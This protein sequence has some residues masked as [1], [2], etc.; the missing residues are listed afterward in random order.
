[1]VQFLISERGM[2]LSATSLFTSAPGQ[3]FEL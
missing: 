1:M 3:V 2:T